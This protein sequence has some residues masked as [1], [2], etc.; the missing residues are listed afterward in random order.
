MPTLSLSIVDS[1]G[2]DFAYD[3]LRRER[4]GVAEDEP[5]PLSV[6][7]GLSPQDVRVWWRSLDAA[8]PR[9]LAQRLGIRAAVSAV[10]RALH[11][12]REEERKES[13]RI[14]AEVEA[15]TNGGIEIE[16]MSMMQMVFAAQNMAERAYFA[17]GARAGQLAYVPAAA[18]LHF[19][20]EA[21]AVAEGTRPSR[22]GL[23]A[24]VAQLVA[25]A[26][27][28]AAC[29]RMMTASVVAQQEAMDHF[30][31]AVKVERQRQRLDLLSVLRE[32]AAAAME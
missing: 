3:Y 18:A 12:L 24:D 5:V 31:A 15:W 13:E 23:L 14:L 29:A 17:A 2:C 19:L 32:A 4:P 16:E 6:W 7:W 27:G 30:R 8:E 1:Q 26:R 21:V 25:E 20:V 11:L 28:D 9:D 10:R 22:V